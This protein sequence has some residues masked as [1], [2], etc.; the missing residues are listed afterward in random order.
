MEELGIEPVI[1]G[2]AG[3][4]PPGIK[5]LY[6]EVN[7]HPT[8]WNGGFPV[9]QRPVVMLPDSPL[10]ASIGKAFIIEWKKEFGEARY[11][12]VDKGSHR[13]DIRAASIVADG[14][15]VASDR[16]DGETGDVHRGNFYRFK[17]PKGLAA[18]NTLVLRAEIRSLA[19]ANSYGRVLC[20]TK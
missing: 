17:L 11:W 3:F 4:V 20:L 14:K 19:G 15:V 1:Q 8:R 5:R 13:L 2:F 18:N 9:S 6:P 16:H 10:W 12:L 7:L